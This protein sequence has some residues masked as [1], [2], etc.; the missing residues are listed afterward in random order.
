MGNQSPE[1]VPSFLQNNKV[2]Q[3]PLEREC[4][5]RAR[6]EAARGIPPR[7]RFGRHDILVDGVVDGL[8]RKLGQNRCCG[9]R[10]Q[11]AGVKGHGCVLLIILYLE[12]IYN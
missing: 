6:S 11:C 9:R 1:Q 4:Q 12:N 3:L 8:Q 2:T 7:S 10:E 5:Q